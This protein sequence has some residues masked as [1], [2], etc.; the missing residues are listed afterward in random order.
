[1][2]RKETPS[3]RVVHPQGR[4]KGLGAA[5]EAVSSLQSTVGLM[6][7]PACPQV[8]QNAALYTG[9]PNLGLELFEAAGDI[10]FNGTW[11]REKAV[12]FYRVSWVTRV[13][14]EG[15]V[16]GLGWQR[17]PT[18]T[19]GLPHALASFL[20]G[21]TW[22]DLDPHPQPGREG[23]RRDCL[24]DRGSFRLTGPQ[25]AG[26]RV[27]LRLADEEAEAQRDRTARQ[28]GDWHRG[29]GL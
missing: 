13:G 21:F 9:D 27:L 15:R 29:P 14:L 22:G 25:T 17:P 10:F 4:L 5:G 18:W 1:M 11:E 26:R 23:E 6:R 20:V 7:V 12:S 3:A 2:E 19:G 28:W 16:T 24:R 8:A